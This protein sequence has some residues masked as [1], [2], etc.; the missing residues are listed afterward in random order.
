MK[1]STIYMIGV[2]LLGIS[3]SPLRKALSN[4]AIFAGLALVYLLILRL[5]A[6]RFGKI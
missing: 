5:L 4:D 1:K 6:Q 3:Y 2:I